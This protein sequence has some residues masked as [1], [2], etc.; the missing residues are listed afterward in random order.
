MKRMQQRK[1][2]GRKSKKPVKKAIVVCWRVIL[3]F[4]SYRMIAL[5][6]MNTER[7]NETNMPITCSMNTILESL[8][9]PLKS[10]MSAQ[11]WIIV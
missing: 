8:I 11:L 1:R 9:L 6:S 3:A 7:D 5:V 10:S 4:S 2:I